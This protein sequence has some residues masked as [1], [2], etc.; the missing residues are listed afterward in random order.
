M[1]VFN[2]LKIAQAAQYASLDSLYKLMVSAKAVK[3]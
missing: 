1:D 3:V 2:P